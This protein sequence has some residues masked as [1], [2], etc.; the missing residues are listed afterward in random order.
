MESCPK[1]I[2]VVPLQTDH[3]KGF[4]KKDRISTK[5]CVNESSSKRCNEEWYTEGRPVR[6]CSKG[7]YNRSD[8]RAMKDASRFSGAKSLRTR[9]EILER[10]S[11]SRGSFE[12]EEEL[13]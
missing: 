4:G 10:P 9:L 12:R 5:E 3:A 1:S 7:A 8:C 6:K 11:D 13:C 2:C